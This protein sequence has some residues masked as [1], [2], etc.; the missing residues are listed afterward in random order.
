MRFEYEVI[1]CSKEK[2]RIGLDSPR[3]FGGIT[4][5]RMEHTVETVGIPV[6]TDSKAIKEAKKIARAKNS[7]ILRL[8]KTWRD[9]D[10]D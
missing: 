9:I 10:A 5:G 3:D 2:N 4:P 7:T 1:L 8:T 6:K